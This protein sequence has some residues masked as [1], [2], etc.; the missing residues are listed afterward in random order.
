MKKTFMKPVGVVSGKGYVNHWQ[1]E[2]I[3]KSK[4]PSFYLFLPN[5]IRL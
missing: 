3:V 4:I 2:T 1:I 5:L